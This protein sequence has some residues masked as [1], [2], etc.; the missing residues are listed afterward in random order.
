MN[1]LRRDSEMGEGAK[2]QLLDMKARFESVTT[3]GK[4][5]DAF[6]AASVL[7]QAPENSAS[8]L[9]AVHYNFVA[10]GMA[11]IWMLGRWND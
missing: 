8:H 4:L 11:A 2:H 5:R 1:A 6:K 3:A 10:S 9:Y 7:E